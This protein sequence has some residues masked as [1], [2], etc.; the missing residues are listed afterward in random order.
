MEDYLSGDTMSRCKKAAAFA[1]TAILL[2]SIT[3]PT[4]SMPA[5]PAPRIFVQPDGSSFEAS[6][7]GDERMLWFETVDTNEVVVYNPLSSSYEYAEVEVD[8][9]GFFLRPSGLLFGQTP[10]N[11]IPEIHYEDLMEAWNTAW[12]G[13]GDHSDHGHGGESAPEAQSGEGAPEHGSAA[14]T[15]GQYIYNSL[16]IMVEF[17]DFQF[18]SDEATWSNKIFGG[19]PSEVSAGSLNDYYQEISQGQLFF[20]PANENQGTANDG[21]IKVQVSGNHPQ[22][23]RDWSGWRT[24]LVEAFNAA[25]NHIDFSQ[26]DTNQNGTIDKTELLVSFIISGRESSYSGSESEG[27]WGHAYFSHNFGSYNGVDVSTGYMGFGE[28]QGPTN[29][30]Y[31]STLGIIAH[32]LGHS[33]FNLRDL[34]NQPTAISYWG[35]MGTGSWGY[36]SGER[37]G[38]RPVHMTAYSKMNASLQNGSRGFFQ[39][40]QVTPS[41]SA[42]LITTSHPFGTADYNFVRLPGEY[43]YQYWLVEQRK[44]EGYD[45]GLLRNGNGTDGLVAGDTGILVSYSQ[46]TSRL[47]INRMSGQ[48]TGTRKTDMMYGGHVTSFTPATT[49]N[50]NYPNSDVFSGLVIEQVSSASEQMTAYVRREAY[51]CTSFTDTLPNHETAGRAYSQVEGQTC[52]GT[53]CYGGSTVYYANGSSENLGSSTWTQITLNE[54]SP[55]YYTTESCPVGDTT[56]PV[57]SLNGSTDITVYQGAAW[58]DPGY[59]ATDETDG[60]ITAN[61]IVSGSVDTATTGDYTLNYNVS[62]AAGNSATQATRVVHVVV[63]PVD[64]TAPVIALIGDTEMTII[65]NTAFSDPGFSATDNTDGNITSLV[66]VSGSVDNTVIGTYELRYNVS[67]AAGNAATEVLRT[68][69]VVAEPEDTTV[70]VITLNGASAITLNVGDN[71]VEPGFSATDNVDGDISAQVVI[72]G[73]VNT[74]IAGDYTLRYNVSDA[75]GNAATEVT[76]TIHVEE[77]TAC[78]EHTASVNAHISAGRAYNCGTYGFNGCAVGSD[79]DIGLT[80]LTTPVTLKE[81][82]LGH[83][84]LGSCN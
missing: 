68:V 15:P 22:Y 61:V 67:D 84:D 30:P 17:D 79:T 19:Y 39:P 13:Y 48:S 3:L 16:F 58:V 36:K 32:E 1:A 75:A 80:F 21:F 46:S 5:N 38:A 62:D 71:Y 49:P 81:Q 73:S 74:N 60:D 25:A 47:W 83:F 12:E 50:T 52:F 45:E 28:R 23:A 44:V 77:V 82:P 57:I 29:A 55:N 41:G 43:S 20:T 72:S 11:V 51:P 31:D 37:L 66:T 14:P 78:V 65:V 8:V 2:C 7:Q 76:R 18:T 27:F 10:L 64:T 26:Y 70:P 56:A 69:N 6:P 4:H 40:Q 9:E 42:Q 34:Y 59:T 24:K 53:F 54:T 63:E 35:L 33:A